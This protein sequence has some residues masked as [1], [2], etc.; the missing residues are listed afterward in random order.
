MGVAGL[1]TKFMEYRA[2]IRQSRTGASRPRVMVR[3]LDNCGPELTGIC[4]FRLGYE[5]R[6][7]EQI[8]QLAENA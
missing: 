4:S 7:L 2:R 3:R 5:M 6:S 1:R 8:S